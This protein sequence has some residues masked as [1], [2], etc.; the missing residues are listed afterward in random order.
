[1]SGQSGET[2]LELLL[3]FAIEHVQ[4]ARLASRGMWDAFRKYWEV[5]R[6]RERDVGL[7]LPEDLDSHVRAFNEVLCNALKRNAAGQHA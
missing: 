3:V 6:A 7:D 5:H 4:L 1:M 2:W